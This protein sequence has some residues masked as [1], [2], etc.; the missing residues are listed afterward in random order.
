M[1][2]GLLWIALTV[3]CIGG[4]AFA[5]ES[6]ADSTYEIAW[7]YGPTLSKMGDLAEITVPEGY[8]FAGAEDTK[9]LMTLMG[10]PVS[11]TEQGFFSP[12]SMEWFA[13]FEFDEV[14]YIKDDEKESLDP[15]GMLESIREAQIEGN[16]RRR[17]MG[18][19]G[20][21]ILGWANEPHYDAATNNL[22]WAI[23]M[24]DD[25]GNH[26]INHNTRILG[27]RGV[28]RVTLVVNPESLDEVLPLYKNYLDGFAY[29]S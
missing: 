23:R 10:N 15:E 5:Q 27:R 20:L 1:L 25:E 3:C 28:M 13:V 29:Q 8:L 14:G 22:E 16:K 26:I 19:S 4:L 24:Q 21:E 17:E 6:E 11:E 7:E 2:R 9:L 18:Y 12:D